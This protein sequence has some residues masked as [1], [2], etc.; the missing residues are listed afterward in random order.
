MFRP[1]VIRG[2]GLLI[3]GL[4][5]KRWP[6]PVIRCTPALGFAFLWPFMLRQGVK[7][8]IDNRSATNRDGIFNNFISL[9]S[10]SFVVFVLIVNIFPVFSNKTWINSYR[11]YRRKMVVM[12]LKILARET[13]LF[14]TSFSCLLHLYGKIFDADT[15]CLYLLVF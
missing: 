11:N 12:D 6:L 3:T 4:L 9:S 15:H 1:L 14:W 8:G 13:L 10:E 5:I 7:M 2:R